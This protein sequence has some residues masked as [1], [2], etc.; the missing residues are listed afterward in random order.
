MR[1]ATAW[2]LRPY[3]HDLCGQFCLNLHIGR[4]E[5]DLNEGAS[6][7]KSLTRDIHLIEWRS[8]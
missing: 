3:T 8:A 2:E 6:G 7:H 4:L 5:A 1:R